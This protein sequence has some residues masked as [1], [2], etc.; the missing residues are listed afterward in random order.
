LQDPIYPPLFQKAFPRQ[1]TWEF[2]QIVSAIAAFERTLTALNSPYDRYLQGKNKVFSESAIRGERLFFSTTLG[3]VHCHHGQLL[4]DG[5]YHRIVSDS[6]HR[7]RTPGLRQ[8]ALTA[9][10][11]HDGRFDTLR[12]AIEGH[13][14]NMDLKE[15]EWRDLIIFLGQLTDTMAVRNPSFGNPWLRVN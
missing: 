11:F 8:V 6:P 13:G 10:Y 1:S 9:P 5:R 7:Y 4:T 2:G 15:T 12:S 14:L 3:C